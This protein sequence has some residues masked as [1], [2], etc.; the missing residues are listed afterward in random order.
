MFLLLCTAVRA[1]FSQFSVQW[2]PVIAR[3]PNIIEATMRTRAQLALCI[4]PTPIGT[5]TPHYFPVGNYK[6]QRQEVQ[7]L[8][9]VALVYA[10]PS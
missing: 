8:E 1:A 7:G 3:P 5:V 2:Q 4:S 6:P 10:Y 9:I